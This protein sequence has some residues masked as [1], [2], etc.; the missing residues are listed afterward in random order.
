MGNK[1]DDRLGGF[2]HRNNKK[3][4]QHRFNRKIK[5]ILDYTRNIEVEGYIMYLPVS[6]NFINNTGSS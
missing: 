5:R 3:R 1:L 2:L 4:K 6:P